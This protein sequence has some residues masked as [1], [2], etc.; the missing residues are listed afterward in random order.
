MAGDL[1]V[2]FHQAVE[3]IGRR[4]SGAVIQLLMQHRLRY[5]ELRAAIPDISDRM[6]SERLRELE[7][8]GI[9]VRTVLPDPPVR[10]EYDLTEK[11][12]ALRP[13]LNAI[14]EW[15]ER[16]VPAGGSATPAGT[17]SSKSS[18]RP[19]TARPASAIT[20]TTAARAVAAPTASRTPVVA[21]RTAA[22]GSP[23]AVAPNDRLRK[24]RPVTSSSR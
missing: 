22:S 13:A 7:A 4:W 17:D 15:A 19:A 24:R 8:A 11:G 20:T 12:R 3:L 14:G 10:V 21:T 6:L 1:C 5:A 16:W 18:P 9:V 23:S 2:R